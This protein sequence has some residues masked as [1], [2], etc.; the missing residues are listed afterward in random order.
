MSDFDD[1]EDARNEDYDNDFTMCP[2][3]HPRHSE[4]ELYDTNSVDSYGDGSNVDEQTG[5]LSNDGD[6]LDGTAEGCMFTYSF[7]PI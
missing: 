6:M 1:L 2:G 3:A 7:T 5:Y 4:A